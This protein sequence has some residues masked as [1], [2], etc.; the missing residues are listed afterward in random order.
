[1]IFYCVSEIYVKYRLFWKKD[2]SHTLS[3]IEILNW[4]KGGYFNVHKAIFHATLRQSTC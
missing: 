3:I 1:M 2:G 4:E